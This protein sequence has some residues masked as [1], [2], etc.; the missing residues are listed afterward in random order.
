MLCN[1]LSEFGNR[2]DCR[3]VS[4]L[5]MKGEFHPITELLFSWAHAASCGLR[6]GCR[7]LPRGWWCDRRRAPEPAPSAESR[8]RR[9][10]LEALSRPDVS[11]TIRDRCDRCLYPSAR[12]C[13]RSSDRG[14][15]TLDGSD[16]ASRAE[17]T[18]SPP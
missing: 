4:F 8:S 1:I 17:R 9:C 12:P 6:S 13:G 2:L 16:P 5:L 15:K 7:D 10:R 3:T 18:T 14:W 11:G